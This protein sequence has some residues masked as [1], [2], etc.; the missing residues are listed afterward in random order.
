MS[1]PRL[2][3]HALK[4]NYCMANSQCDR[5]Y[6]KIWSRSQERK[7][8]NTVSE[9]KGPLDGLAEVRM[10]ESFRLYVL[11]LWLRR[12]IERVGLFIMKITLTVVGK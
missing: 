1:K 5:P 8:R 7:A 12:L 10:C 9:G 2:L 4:C 6:D 11:G 3:P